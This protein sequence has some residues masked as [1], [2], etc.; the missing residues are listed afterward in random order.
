MLVLRGEFDLT[1]VRQFDRGHR[2]RRSD[3]VAA[4]SP[5]RPVVHGLGVG[6]GPDRPVPA[7]GRR[8]LRRSSWPLPS[9]RSASAADHGRGRAAD[10]R[11]TDADPPG[12]CRRPPRR[13]PQRVSLLV[14]RTS[15]AGH[16]TASADSTWP[17]SLQEF[18]G[19]F[20]TAWPTTSP[21]DRR[22]RM[23]AGATVPQALSPG[24]RPPG[25]SPAEAATFMFS[26]KQPLFARLA[27]ELP[28]R[29]RR[30][31]RL[32]PRDDRAR[33]S[34]RPVHGR[35]VRQSRRLASG[36]TE[37]VAELR[38]VAHAEVAVAVVHQQVALA[39][40]AWRCSAIGAPS[41]SSSSSEYR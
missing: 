34:A 25:F 41:S 23:G 20:A 18:L 31:D 9:L 19:L 7:R 33:R 6:L 2:R 11:S 39:R 22:P 30:P 17:G 10:G 29:R 4:C 38:G 28:G 24:S 26:L 1:G 8:G 13:H 32:D 14:R 16:R 15:S 5:A 36:A 27:N 37:D 12:G 35:R 3:R 21:A 40:L